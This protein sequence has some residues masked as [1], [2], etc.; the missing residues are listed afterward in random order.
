MCKPSSN[1]I[2]PKPFFFG[3]AGWSYPDWNGIVYPKPKP[4]TFN[5]LHFLAKEFNFVEVNTTFYRTPSLKLTSGWVKKTEALPKFQFW[6]KILQ[7]FTHRLT[8]NNFEVRQFKQSLTPLIEAGKLTGL[9]A[10]FPYSFKLNQQNLSYVY[11]LRKAFAEST[12]AI[13]FRHQSWNQDE[14]LDLF[15][16]NE[17]IWVNI[18]QPVISYSLPL[19]THFTHPAI[20]YFRLH[21]RNAKSWFSNEGRD[22]RYNYDYCASELNLIATQINKLKNMAKKIFISGNNHFQGSAVKNLIAL[23]KILKQK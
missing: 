21:G 18:D 1:L 7:N 3:T 11:E 22:A 4:K 23:K 12:L 14:V 6:I 5:P 15:K 2:E 19:T 20:T 16:S 8:L 13:E 10:Q 17:I 9:L